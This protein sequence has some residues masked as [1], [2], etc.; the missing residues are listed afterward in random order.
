[1]M[2]VWGGAFILE[3]LF[4]SGVVSDV[5]L[6]SIVLVSGVIKQRFDV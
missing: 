1:M 4:T 3:L 2:L 5:I 6:P